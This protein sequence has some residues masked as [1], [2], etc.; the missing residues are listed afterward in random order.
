MEALLL[1]LDVGSAS[2]GYS[3][4]ASCVDSS[5][6]TGLCKTTTLEAPIERFATRFPV[7]T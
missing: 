1:T 2:L 3:G 7:N 4:M 5:N 6:P